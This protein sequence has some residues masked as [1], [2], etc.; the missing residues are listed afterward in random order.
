LASQD[1][2]EPQYVVTGANNKKQ[3]ITS[4]QLSEQERK[5]EEEKRMLEA[6][7]AEDLQRLKTGLRF[8]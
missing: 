6:R 3:V 1:T 4:Q 5:L 7:Y 8:N 2:R